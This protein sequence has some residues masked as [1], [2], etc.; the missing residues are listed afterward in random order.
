MYF[1]LHPKEGNE[2]EYGST[3]IQSVTTPFT[4]LESG[5]ES[6]AREMGQ[7]DAFLRGNKVRNM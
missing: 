3:N 7:T 1:Y 5:T 6:H 2:Y 4:S